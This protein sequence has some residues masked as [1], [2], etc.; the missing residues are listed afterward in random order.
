[1]SINYCHFRLLDIYYTRKH[2]FLPDKLNVNKIDVNS[3][4]RL[5]TRQYSTFLNLIQ[6]STKCA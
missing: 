5:P 4:H 1:M 6:L 2:A 3:N